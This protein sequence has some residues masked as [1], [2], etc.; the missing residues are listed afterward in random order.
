MMN[1][2][3]NERGFSLV[4]LLIVIGITAIL[5]TIV[6]PNFLGARNKYVIDGDTEKMIAH[7]RDG[8]DRARAQKDGVSWGFGINNGDQDWYELLQG[9]VGGTSV[10]RVYLSPVVSFTTNS[11]ST[12][13]NGGPNINV[14]NSDFTIGLSASDGGFTDTIVIDTLGRISR[15]SS[16]E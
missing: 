15:T 3:E 4:E 16:Y 6:L 10:D 12:T 5:G 13:F 2:V 7:I 8:I 14:L 1:R 9:G 11:T